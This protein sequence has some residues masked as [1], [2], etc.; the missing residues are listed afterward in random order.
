MLETNVA[1]DKLKPV[2]IYSGFPLSAKHVLD[3]VAAQVE[4]FDAVN[5]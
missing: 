2:L 4:E 3:A 5:R 1:K